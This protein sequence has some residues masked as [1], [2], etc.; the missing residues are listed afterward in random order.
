MKRKG[1]GSRT[2][3]SPTECHARSHAAL[4]ERVLGA[5]FLGDGLTTIARRPH[6]PRAATVKRWIARD[7]TFRERYDR[8]RQDSRYVLADEMMAL[9]KDALAKA[10]TERQRTAALRMRLDLIKWWAKT[11]GDDRAA[12]RRAA[13]DEGEMMVKILNDALEKGR[14]EALAKRDTTT[15]DGAEDDG[16]GDDQRGSDDCGG[17]DADDSAL[18]RRAEIASAP[19]R[20]TDRLAPAH[21]HAAPEP[22]LDRY[23][24]PIRRD[25]PGS[26]TVRFDVEVPR[27]RHED[28]STYDPFR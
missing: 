17:D 7:P 3:L 8:A 12:R 18:S 1:Q 13:E 5:V 27:P 6:M 10:R 16:P 23:G 15:S 28:L 26:W 21:P 2:P 25:P 11:F 20:S 4:Q 22:E 9:A 14:A 24:F 19:R